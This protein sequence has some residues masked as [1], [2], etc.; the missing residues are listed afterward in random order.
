MWQTSAL[1]PHLKEHLSLRAHT[2]ALTP[3]FYVRL[4][5]C[6]VV[7]SSCLAA[8]QAST[9]AEPAHEPATHRSEGQLGGEKG[10]AKVASHSKESSSQELSGGGAL[11]SAQEALLSVMGL[12][13]QPALTG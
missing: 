12:I 2:G 5:G 6:Q 4:L 8:L 13:W 11:V 3:S 7:V 10:D 1:V 9:P